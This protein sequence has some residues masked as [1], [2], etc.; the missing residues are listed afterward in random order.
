MTVKKTDLL[1][2][3]T[4]RLGLAHVDVAESHHLTKWPDGFV[5]DHVFVRGLREVRARAIP[6]NGSD[7]TAIE[8]TFRLP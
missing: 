4:A 3:E 7:H 1:F 5:L 2:A 8:L 6:G